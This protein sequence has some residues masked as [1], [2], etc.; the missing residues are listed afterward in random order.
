MLIFVKQLGGST[1]SFEIDS[2]ASIG[3]LKVR[4]KDSQGIPVDQQRLIFAGRQLE[5]LRTLADYNIQKDSTIHL[6]RQVHQAAVVRYADVALTPPGGA[7]DQFLRLTSGTTASQFLV[8]VAGGHAHILTFWVQGNLVW[9]LT[10]AS[11][12]GTVTGIESASISETG[13]T[14]VRHDTTVSAPAGSVAAT[15]DLLSSN[16]TLMIDRVSFA[17]AE[18][19]QSPP[20]PVTGLTATPGD[21]RVHLEWQGPTGGSPATGYRVFW[22]R[23]DNMIATTGT[24]IDITVTNGVATRFAVAAVNAAGSST[25]VRTASITP[26]PPPG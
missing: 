19:L 8:G 26:T 9:T 6:V 4:V 13:P 16:G 23:H 15:L 3:D 21:G 1:W 24:A 25:R 5:D 12:D 20:G 7:G 2:T 10:F 22:G 11:G 18:A 17:T 14:L